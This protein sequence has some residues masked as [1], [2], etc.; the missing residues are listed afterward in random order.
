M[1]F[2]IIAVT[3]S[4]I[5]V[6]LT[7]LLVLYPMNWLQILLNKCGLN[8]PGLR[9][10]MECFQGY[11]CDRS[12]GGRECRYFA[13]VYPAMK[14]LGVVLFAATHSNIFFSL[15]ILILIIVTLSLLPVQLYKKEFYNKMEIVLLYSL[16]AFGASITISLNFFDWDELLPIFGF[17]TAGLIS[18]IPFFYLALL[19]VRKMLL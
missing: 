11:Y 2:F 15:Y 12:D 14:I 10:F 6:V 9:M 5:A 7:L 16:V 4:L 8:S 13:A 18:F 17:F 3:A 1:P 19:I